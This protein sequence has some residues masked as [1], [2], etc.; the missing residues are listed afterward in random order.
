MTYGPEKNEVQKQLLVLRR[1]C[2]GLT[3]VL[4]IVVLAGAADPLLRYSS[5]SRSK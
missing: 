3:T 4:G 1:W 2:L 5:A